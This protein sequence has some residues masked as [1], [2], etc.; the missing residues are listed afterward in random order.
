MRVRMTVQEN[1]F[2]ARDVV[3]E[4]EAGD[5]VGDVLHLLRAELR[6][7][8]A[9]LVDGLPLDPAQRVST[10]PL[11]NG[12]VVTTEPSFAR[13]PAAS[14][15]VLRVISGED[16]D[17]AVPLRPG[18]PV[19]VGRGSEVDVD[20]ADLDVSRLHCELRWDGRTARVA[21][22]GSRNHTFVSGREVKGE[23]VVGPDEY[24]QAGGTRLVVDRTGFRPA[25]V[26]DD[27]EGGLRVARAPRVR[28]RPW[29][30]AQIDFPREPEPL[31]ENDFPMLVP[32]LGTAAL[33]VGALFISRHLGYVLI[34][35]A[36]GLIG[37]FGMRWWYKRSHRRQTAARLAAHEAKVEVRRTELQA[38][39]DEESAHLHATLPST[40]SLIAVGADRDHRLWQRQRLDDDWLHLRLGTTNR[41]TSARLR[42]EPAGCEIP[43]LTG[44]PLGLSLADQPALGVAGMPHQT[45]PVVNALLVQSAVLH[46]PDELRIAVIA[47]GVDDLGWARWLPHVKASSGELRAAW[48][49]E[50]VE[51]LVGALLDL[52]QDREST[53]APQH[54]VVLVGASELLRV[55][56]VTDLLD[57]GPE[58]GLRFLCVDGAAHQLPSVCRAVLDLAGGVL[59]RDRD[60]PLPFAPERVSRADAERVARSLAPLRV[61]GQRTGGALPEIVRS[62][63]LIGKPDAEAVRAAWRLKPAETAVCVGVSST[64][65]FVLDIVRDGP[66]AVVVGTTHA[67]KSGFLV[68]LITGLAAVSTPEQLNFLFIDYK[69][70]A[71]VRRLS[72]LP[73]VVGVAD[74]LSGDPTRVLAV[75]R[76][77][78]ER[79]QRQLRSANAEN[80]AEYRAKASVN[81]ALPPFPRLVVVVDELAELNARLDQAVDELISVARTGATLGVHLVLATQ[82]PGD[83][84]GK[85]TGNVALRVCLRVEER[86]ES[87]DIIGKPHAAA[88]GQHQRGRAFILRSSVLHEVQTAFSSSPVVESE[89]ANTLLHP[90]E[91]WQ[92]DVPM[93]DGDVTSAS[94]T[95]VDDL[96]EAI[97]EAAD[98]LTPPF[99]TWVDPLPEVVGLDEILLTRH[100]LPI[101]V[102]EVL[103]EQAHRPLTLPLGTGHLAVVGAAQSGRTSA[104]RAMAVGLMDTNSPDEVHLHVIDSYRGLAGALASAPHCGVAVDADQTWR[105]DRLLTR[106][107]A[108]VD[109]RLSLLARRGASSV[110]ELWATGGDGP[111]HLVLLVDGPEVLMDDYDRTDR[112]LRLLRR[113]VAAG[114]TACVALRESEAKQKLLELCPHRLVLA[115]T[116]DSRGGTVGLPSRRTTVGNPA[117]RGVWIE[118]RSEVQA[119]LLAGQSQRD[120]VIAAAD[121][122]RARS[123]SM[124]S[125][126]ITVDPLPEDLSLD[127]PVMS[128]VDGRG[129]AVLGVAGDRLAAVGVD[130]LREHRT[131]LVAGPRRSGRSTAV[132]S[133]AISLARSGLRVVL[134]G[135]RKSPAYANAVAHGID[136]V[137]AEDLP[138][139]VDV[140]VV[141]DADLAADDAALVRAPVLVGAVDV[142]RAGM[143]PYG[144]ELMKRLV[145]ARAGVLLSPPGG[146]TALGVKV[147]RP[148]G[149][150]N[151]PG[152]AYLVL[153]GDMVLGQVPR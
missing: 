112:V 106:L 4:C 114:L 84:A 139:D 124:R 89:A 99:A 41:K 33:A 77:E 104:L 85:I 47:P 94:R 37:T 96:V 55:P 126:P 75:L 71:T 61:V 26:E 54:V 140:V 122:A 81:P 123:T 22:L 113:G 74:N 27:G 153:D 6:G 108:E 116:D 48:R 70:G 67:G 151:P 86:A 135:G 120:V 100:Q 80:I 46:G 38:A 21:D 101:G 88:I 32:L 63:D 8:G 64:G 39:A 78:L 118:D 131:L 60:D 130:V 95:D 149:F 53:V 141:D 14:G 19:R 51:P 40:A 150:S 5:L 50:Q 79:R 127:H 152:R 1:G 103:A 18:V 146:T 10:S 97:R 147:P 90:R 42:D 92:T 23:Q 49:A 17:L 45:I 65:N 117:G 83:V 109:E 35:I 76:A 129:H 2:S 115:L 43:V 110:A 34:S 105:V 36:V 57:R 28:P 142:E 136:L 148:A 82:L 7:G 107:E 91:W 72:Q 59:R 68:T 132:C 144:N 145:A 58:A 125:A 20:L 66:H 93:R 25:E 69:G 121:A 138:S 62:R 73:H 13:R 111:P 102:Q 16:T 3:L 128:A 137:S 29:A 143:A 52:V 15:A 98:G 133:I 9:P 11:K 56:G 24:V 31:Q 30:G 134:V 44:A 12:A 119:P 87:T